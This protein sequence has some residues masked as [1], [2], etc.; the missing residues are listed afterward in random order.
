ATVSVWAVSPDRAGNLWVCTETAGLRRLNPR[1]GQVRAYHADP[2]NPAS[3]SN[4]TV[5]SAF[6]DRAGTLWVGTYGGGLNARH[7][8]G[9]P[10]FYHY[11]TPPAAPNA[12]NFNVVQSLSRD[13]TGRLWVGSLGGL[14]GL[15]GTPDSMY[16]EPLPFTLTDA[17]GV[18][19]SIATRSGTQW[20]G[21]YSKGVLSYEPRSGKQ[22]VFTEITRRAVRVAPRQMAVGRVL[23]DYAGIL[24]FTT[25][26]DGLRAYDPR[27]GAVRVYLHEANNPASLSENYLTA[28]WETPDQSLWVG[29]FGGGLC[30]LDSGRGRF[31]R[32]LNDPKNGASI[33]NNRVSCLLGEPS[34]RLWVGTFGGGLNTLDPATGRWQRFTENDGLPNNVINALLPDGRGN[35]WL[36]TNKGLCRFTPPIAG[37]PALIRAFDVRDGLQNNEFAMNSGFRDAGGWLYFGG[38]NGFNVFHPDRITLNP[39]RPPVVLTDFRV[40]EKPYPLDSLISEKKALTLDYAQNFFSFE[41]AAL[42][43]V[44]SEKNRYA[45]RMEGFN[46]DWVE[47]GTRR[48]ASYTNLPPGTYTFRVKAANNDGVWNEQG[49]ALS[50]TIVPPFWQT[51]WFRVLLLAGFLGLV[52]VLL[53]ARWERERRANELRRIRAEAETK[54]LRAQMNPHFIFNCLNTVD[55]YI[56]TNR[57]DDASLFLQKFSQLIRRVLEQSR[58]EFIPIQQE[59]ETLELYVQLEEE[60][61]E[62]R[63]RHVFQV[64]EA[65][66]D[67]DYQIPPMLLQPFLEN[68]ILHG[69][70]HKTDG[71]G[72]LSLAF[73]VQGLALSVVIE[74][75]GIGREAAGK[76]NAQRQAGRESLGSRVSTDRL[77]TLQV[78]YGAESRCE[79]VDLNPG[80]MVVLTL[81]LL[82]Q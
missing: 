39:Y 45:Y 66:L 29:T 79:Y 20:F 53:R 61:S 43:F 57:Q 41:F 67:G 55:G 32:Y 25:E 17:D 38:I 82:K 63:F 48:Y 33:S 65:V 7:R 11:Q 9:N 50:I 62:N 22:R 15:R 59:I 74:D 75:N 23:E 27:T 72:V 58:Q 76:L 77:A 73:K 21:T 8:Y 34:G 19:T 4:E 80:T 35:L 70:R 28:L 78:L 31:T 36:S 46:E 60:R 1:T 68:A 37:K 71:P 24:W 3:L 42:N 64:D 56:L 51:A 40:F 2:R 18:Q 54:A 6:E 44:I 12:A 81:P 16:A 49:A 52:Y 26:G 10:G 13:F 5:L 69:L 30:R 14:Q 47:A